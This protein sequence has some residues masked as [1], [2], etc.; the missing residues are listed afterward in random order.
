MPVIMISAIRIEDRITIES[1]TGSAWQL[2]PDKKTFGDWFETIGQTKML[3]GVRSVY[4]NHSDQARISIAIQSTVI[5]TRLYLL[6]RISGAIA[7]S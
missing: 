1:V 4:R 5:H 7:K 3:Q 2:R 6:C